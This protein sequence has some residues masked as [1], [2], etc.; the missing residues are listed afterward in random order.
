MP[1]QER[2]TGQYPLIGSNGEIARVSNFKAEG[3]GVVTGRSGS[4]GKLFYV[5]ERYWP[6]NTAL[7]VTDFCGNLP[8]F[9]FYL[10]QTL[11]L[12]EVA[13]GTGVPTLNRNSVH[14]IEVFV[15][16]EQEE[17][18]RIVAIL[19]EAFEGLARAH[20]NVETNLV[21]AKLLFEEQR[22]LLLSPDQDGFVQVTV[23]DVCPR[24]E[25]GSSAKSRPNGPVPVL[26]MGN[27]Q[28]GELDWSDLVFSDDKSEIERYRLNRGDVLFNRTNSAEHVGKTAIYDGSRPAIF[29]GYLIR[30]HRDENRIDGEY[31]TYYLNSRRAREYGATV[32]GRSVNQANI[33][34]A[35]LREY[36]L[37]LPSLKRQREI[38]KALNAIRQATSELTG[39]YSAKL[40]GMGALRQSLLHKAFS[41]QLT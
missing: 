39:A 1:T 31:L 26:R 41:G 18:R 40:E 16:N 37:P 5:E 21:E 13:S 36:P 33:S 14:E 6:L 9:V 28:N 20:E 27:I 29:A 22:N 15:P 7:F 2:Q 3:P 17:Q 12:N 30:I 23:G 25:Y 10:L 35:K 4:I 32:M 19:D 24:F 38:V 8:K 34:A 11:R